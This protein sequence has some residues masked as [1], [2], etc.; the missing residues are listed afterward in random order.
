MISIES[1][2]NIRVGV[3]LWSVYRKLNGQPL[4]QSTSQNLLLLAIEG[5]TISFRA[6]RSLAS[7][8]ENYLNGKLHVTVLLKDVQLFY[9]RA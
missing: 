4:R 6:S 5:K 2:C 8:A 1:A 7:V 3:R 9:Q